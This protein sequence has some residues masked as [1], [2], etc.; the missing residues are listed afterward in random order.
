[1]HDAFPFGLSALQAHFPGAVS[2]GQLKETEVKKEVSKK[3][4][5]NTCIRKKKP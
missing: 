2:E 3:K 4:Q 5:Q 1:M